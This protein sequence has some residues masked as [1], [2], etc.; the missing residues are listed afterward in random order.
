MSALKIFKEILE[1]AF[2]LGIL[3]FAIAFDVLDAWIA[4]LGIGLTLWGVYELAKE[5]RGRRD[6][7]VARMA[8]ERR[9]IERGEG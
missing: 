7:D 4:F 9:R 5:L 2:G 6:A 1:I 3:A 8:E